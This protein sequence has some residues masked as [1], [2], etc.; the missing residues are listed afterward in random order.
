MEDKEGNV[1][2]DQKLCS[3]DGGRALSKGRWGTY[4]KK[5]LDALVKPLST[6]FRPISRTLS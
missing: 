6:H 1:K 3:E 5:G 2:T 4:R